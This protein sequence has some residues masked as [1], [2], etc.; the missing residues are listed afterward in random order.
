MLRDL[1]ALSTQKRIQATG[2]MVT[3]MNSS[4]RSTVKRSDR[5]GYHFNILDAIIVL[6]ILA[7]IAVILVAYL[8]GGLSASD[9][10]RGSVTVTYTLEIKGAQR[11]LADWIA[12]G[13]TVTERTSAVG[14]GRVSAEVEVS[15]AG[16]VRFDPTSG[17]VIIDEA[18]DLSD[19]LITIT[20]TAKYDPSRGYTVNGKRLA[21]GAVY[22]VSLPRFEGAGECI[23]IIE[24]SSNGGVVQ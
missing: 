22:S 1:G 18:E 14:L 2:A 11:K 12:V 19:L 13:D 10:G 4:E 20:T 24:T 7:V 6:V 23:G 5:R 3:T 17:E 16:V 15:P 8:P 21:V 9:S